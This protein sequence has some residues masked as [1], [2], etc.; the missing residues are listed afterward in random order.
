MNAAQIY[1]LE[2][3]LLLEGI[4][5]RYGYDFQ[6]YAASSLKRRVSSF[7]KTRHH[8]SPGELLPS[9]L[10]DTAVFWEFVSH[11]SVPF[12]ELFRDPDS[13]RALREQVIPYL[14]TFPFLKV[15]IAGCATG[16]E[17]YSMAILLY[18]EGLL[19]RT[20]IYC[21]DVNPTVLATAK[22]GRYSSEKIQQ[23]L[24]NYE[25]SG[26]KNTWLDY[27]TI[28]GAIGTVCPKIKQAL[29]FSKHNLTGDE[30]FG[31]MHLVLC[32][33]VLIYFNP[34][35]QDHVLTLLTKSVS[36]RGYLC[37][38]PK[39]SFQSS[40]VS[41]CYDSCSPENSIFRLRA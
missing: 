23:A 10:Q 32:R 22:K 11:L 5:R 30:V 31:E 1:Q 4:F 34:E 27:F 18:E 26:G 2:I 12:T 40:S 21:T 39:E 24:T 16:E 8:A 7:L 36:R 17:A 14:H 25:Q 35:L 41:V 37:L 6:H 29:T 28:Q 15:W 38:G 9:I 3:D 33:N 19:D 20:Q 13:F